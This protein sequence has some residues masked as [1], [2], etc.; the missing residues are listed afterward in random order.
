MTQT[1]ASNNAERL[2]IAEDYFAK[3]MELEK[4]HGDEL[5]TWQAEQASLIAN[6]TKLS[7]DQRIAA[8]DA[9]SKESFVL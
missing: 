7:F 9:L 2:K 8:M 5:A 1:E 6:N 4:V 3:K